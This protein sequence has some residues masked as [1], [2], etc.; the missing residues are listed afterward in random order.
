VRARG[1]DDCDPSRRR[2]SSLVRR[3]F[4]CL[5]AFFVALCDG[6]AMSAGVDSAAV[7]YWLSPDQKELYVAVATPADRAGDRLYYFNNDA[8]RR[9]YTFTVAGRWKLDSTS[10]TMSSDDGRGSL[11]QS[12]QGARDLKARGDADLVAAAIEAYERQFTESLAALSGQGFE[13]TAKATF[14]AAPFETSARKAT[15]WTASARAQRHGREASINQHEVIVEVSPGWVLAIEARDDVAREAIESLG[16][17]APPDCYWPLI[18]ERFPQVV[19]G[20]V[21]F[22]PVLDERVA[23]PSPVS[24]LLSGPSASPRQASGPIRGWRST[25]PPLR[26]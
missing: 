22:E 4:A 7:T 24:R 18:R 8:S 1:I 11:G 10:G 13:I 16:T 26:S 21:G 17:A 19:V 20:V 23:S 12:V 14:S 3:G 6:Q 15:K 9:C 25:R 2:E 5:A